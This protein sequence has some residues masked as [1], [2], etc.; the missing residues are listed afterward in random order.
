MLIAQ[1]IGK[2][3]R[4]PRRAV[5]FAVG[6]LKETLLWE[7]YYARLRPPK[8]RAPVPHD[9]ET[10]AAIVGELKSNGFDVAA[11]VI[12]VSDYRAYLDKA[13]YA[14]FPD[15]FCGGTGPGFAEK[16][17]EHYLAARVLRLSRDD[18]Y[19]D[20]ASL[21][22][23][24]PEIYQRLYGCTV[25]RQDLIYPR[26]LH[27]NVIGGDAGEMPVED[28][29]ATKM[30]LHCSFEHFEQDSDVRFIREAARGLRLGGK[31]CIV[32]L[33]LFTEYAIETD[34]LLLSG[35]GM[36]FETDAVL[37]CRRGSSHWHGR[38]YDV[39][40]FAARV[41]KALNGLQLT[42]LVV[43]NAKEV[44]PGCYLRFIALFEK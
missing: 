44:D 16:S 34:P 42:I 36:S 27:G 12:D 6:K 10:H 1:K 7:L 33:Y 39:P 17:L 38:F 32:P 26:G 21:A 15:Y 23:P 30:A 37:Y 5:R 11:L 18:V 3:L 43:Q 41:G 13:Q 8:V 20:V 9:A 4:N 2:A 24:A 28:G 35:R 22:S 31:L 25:Y 14:S 40:H 29:F 19:V